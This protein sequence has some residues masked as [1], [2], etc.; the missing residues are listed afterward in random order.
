[1][2]T[3]ENNSLN[4]FKQIKELKLNFSS[5]FCEQNDCYTST[6]REKVG[7]A[8]NLIYFDP[9]VKEEFKQKV[10]AKF[11]G[12]DEAKM[13]PLSFGYED[14]MRLYKA[15]L[16][17]KNL[18]KSCFISSLSDIKGSDVFEDAAVSNRAY[19]PKLKYIQVGA[20]GSEK[21]IS[22]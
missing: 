4:I 19:Y 6:V 22:L 8:P 17:C 10:A 20:D 1:M 11:T 14:I 13:T 18:D 7:F 21:E 5:L 9:L 3:Y 2:M 15:S 16:Q 12:I